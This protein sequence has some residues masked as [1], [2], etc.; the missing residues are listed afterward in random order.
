[1]T[2]QPNSADFR[3]RRVRGPT[4]VDGTLPPDM[5][6]SKSARNRSRFGSESGPGV[7]EQICMVDCGCTP[8]CGCRP[9][10][11]CTAEPPGGPRAAAEHLS[12]VNG[13]TAG[14]SLTDVTP[15]GSTGVF[16]VPPFVYYNYKNIFLFLKY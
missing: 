7:G 10:C 12:E 5:F 14:A 6:A 1:M 15:G 2:S 3:L 4:E 8:V 9:D 13:P 11:A 16:W